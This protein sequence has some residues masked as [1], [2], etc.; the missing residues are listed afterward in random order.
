MSKDVDEPAKE[1]EPKEKEP[2]EKAE[3]TLTTGEPKPK[4]SR[5]CSFNESV[6][7]DMVRMALMF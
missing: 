4:K 3:K 1:K 5:K 6:E 7:D 2:K